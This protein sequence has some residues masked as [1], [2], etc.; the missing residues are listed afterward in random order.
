[1]V[2]RESHLAE[3]IA[4]I[5]LVGLDGKTVSARVPLQALPLMASPS[6]SGTARVACREEAAEE[7]RMERS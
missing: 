5:F 3:D 1:M 7:S 2:L 6:G 4:A